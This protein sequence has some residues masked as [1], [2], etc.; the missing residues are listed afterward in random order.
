MAVFNVTGMRETIVSLHKMEKDTTA[1]ADA[2][3][4]TAA[5]IV[6]ESWRYQIAAHGHVD[7]GALFDS[8]KPGK[9]KNVGGNRGVV[10]FPRGKDK[11][12]RT[13]PVT[14]AEKGMIANYGREHQSGTHWR[15]KADKAA[16]DP[17]VEAMENIFDEWLW[18]G[19]L[20]TPGE[21]WA[22][23]VL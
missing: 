8:I 4:S 10:V 5:A 16:E 6:A 18:T 22:D 2:M 9:P 7:T 21:D 1:V 15:D 20:P 17:A 3:V 13:K 14:N 11:K 23:F 12:G 19:N